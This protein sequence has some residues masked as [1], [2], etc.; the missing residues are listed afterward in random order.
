M[1]SV[2]NIFLHDWGETQMLGK[3]TGGSHFRSKEHLCYFDLDNHLRMLFASVTKTEE[4]YKPPFKTKWFLY[5][6]LASLD[7]KAS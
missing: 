5:L 6:D 1:I 3:P 4:R 7:K 2:P